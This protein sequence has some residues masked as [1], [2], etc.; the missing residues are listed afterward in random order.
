MSFSPLHNS[1]RATRGRATRRLGFLT[2]NYSFVLFP[3]NCI[4]CRC[5]QDLSSLKPYQW[6][7]ASVG[8]GES[9]RLG[10]LSS[11]TANAR[12][13]GN[14]FFVFFSDAVTPIAVATIPPSP[15]AATALPPPQQQCPQSYAASSISS[16]ILPP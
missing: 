1:D 3:D 4:G 14:A 2:C 13:L 5:G 12:Y 7:V 9:W 10:P 15:A 8:T 11:K 6:L 16:S